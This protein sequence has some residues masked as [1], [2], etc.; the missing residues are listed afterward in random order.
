MRIWGLMMATPFIAPFKLFFNADNI[1]NQLLF[2]IDIALARNHDALCLRRTG[3]MHGFGPI[4]DGRGPEADVFEEAHD[5]HTVLRWNVFVGSE[6][7][8]ADFA[9][10]FAVSARHRRRLKILVGRQGNHQAAGDVFRQAD[11]FIGEAGSS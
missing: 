5:L 9:N 10:G 7:F 3:P 4:T 8:G 1:L 11:D 2:A 6:V